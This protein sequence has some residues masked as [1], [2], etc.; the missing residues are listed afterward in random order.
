MAIE[1]LNQG[2]PSSASQIPFFD[3]G[4]GVDRRMSV[5]DLATLIQ[6]LLTSG[7]GM[8]TQYA[9]PN[10]TGFSVTVSPPTDGA[11]V[12]LLM[13]PA[14]GYAAGTVVLPASA[15]DGQEVLVSC[16]QAVTALTVNGNGAA[17]VYGAPAALAA[18]DFFRLRYD[19]VLTSWFRIG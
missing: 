7:G 8:V 9:A 3:T 10:A 16:T 6:S 13:T 2:T 14:A 1:R 18:N 4:N 15:V 19:G 5:S 12:W 17:A 11:A